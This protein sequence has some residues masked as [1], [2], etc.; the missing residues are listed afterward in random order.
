MKKLFACMALA[1]TLSACATV[2]AN[3]YVD[4]NYDGNNSITDNAQNYKTI[5]IS[6][7]GE[8]L[9]ADSIVYVDQAKNGFDSA[10]SFLLKE[11]PEPGYYTVTYGT[12]DP[13]IPVKKSTF[14]IGKGVTIQSADKMSF[15]VEKNEEDYTFTGANGTTYKRAYSLITDAER[16]QSYKS[17]KL[18]YNDSD[19][20][21]SED[22]FTVMGAYP[23]SMMFDENTS[24]SGESDVFLFVQFHGMSKAE[25]DNAGKW[26]VFFSTDDV[27]AVN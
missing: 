16:Y 27:V 14:V 17:I 5:L 24:L 25:Y 20:S 22:D 9:S 15:I 10:T 6:K 7:M 13:D 23:K 2:F 1:L 8:E 21:N 12:D 19:A 26:D 4:Y 18:V 11:N 3:D